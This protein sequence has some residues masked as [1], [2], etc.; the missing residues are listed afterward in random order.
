MIAI[1]LLPDDITGDGVAD[2]ALATIPKFKKKVCT[3]CGEAI[4]GL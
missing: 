2:D 4:Y 3:V 1:E